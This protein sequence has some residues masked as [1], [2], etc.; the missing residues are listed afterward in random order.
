MFCFILTEL[1]LLIMTEIESF[2]SKWREF[3]GLSGE[4]RCT[5]E[6]IWFN[7]EVMVLVIKKRDNS[8]W[9]GFMKWACALRL[10]LLDLDLY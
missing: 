10:V 1:L 8:S 9:S 2:Q 7:V 5:R 3:S 6:G 4:F